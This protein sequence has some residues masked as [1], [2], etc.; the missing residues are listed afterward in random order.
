MSDGKRFGKTQRIMNG[1][2]PMILVDLGR[3]FYIKLRPE[4]S[5]T[6]PNMVFGMI[7]VFRSLKVKS[8]KL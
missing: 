3:G 8:Q 6:I 7:M 4:R 1:V 5:V 2:Q